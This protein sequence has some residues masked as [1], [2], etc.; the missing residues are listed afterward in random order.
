M[1]AFQTMAASAFPMVTALAAS[2]PWRVWVTTFFAIASARS[3]R[4]NM[5]V[6]MW[7]TVLY[8]GSVRMTRMPG[9]ARSLRPWICFGLPFWTAI[10]GVTVATAQASVL[11]PRFCMAP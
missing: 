11:R 9:F 7:P 8:I 2:P 6:L 5:T 1:T 3:A 10:I 4:L